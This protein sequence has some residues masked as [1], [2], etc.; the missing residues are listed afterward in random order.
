MRFCPVCS[1][2][3]L[4]AGAILA[5]E[6]QVHDH[7]MAGSVGALNPGDLGPQEAGQLHEAFAGL[8]VERGGELGV[9]G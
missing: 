5:G 6:L 8:L 3:P 4:G 1:E 2:G 9:Q 7:R